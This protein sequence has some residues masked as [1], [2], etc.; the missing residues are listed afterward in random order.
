MNTGSLDCQPDRFQPDIIV[1]SPDGEYLM[2]VEIKFTSR[3][4]DQASQAIAQ[5]KQ[6]MVG[7]GC[8]NAL[9]IWGETIMLLRD[10]FEQSDGSSIRVIGA[11]KLPD[12]LLPPTQNQSPVQAE[13]EFATRVQ[14]WM[15][16]LALTTNV[17]QMPEDLQRL[18][19]NPI[20]NL[21]RIGEIRSGGPRWNKA[22]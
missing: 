2:L 9:L 10:S 5:L 4:V 8:P 21:L 1:V 14:Q 15:E 11:A 6:Y 3:G 19:S 16:E 13:W 7:L 12:T 18:F 22:I 20:L 17:R